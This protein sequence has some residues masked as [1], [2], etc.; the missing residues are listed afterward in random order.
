MK[1][2]EVIIQGYYEVEAKN[3]DEA[4]K[5]TIEAQKNKMVEIE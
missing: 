2:Y 4:I 5:K 3:E 1:I